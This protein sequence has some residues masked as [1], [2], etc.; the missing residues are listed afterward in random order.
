MN[1]DELIAALQTK[2]DYL[3]N[4][5]G[6]KADEIGVVVWDGDDI[7]PVTD[8]DYDKFDEDGPWVVEV[9][10]ATDP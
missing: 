10:K 7:A 1:L 2:R 3:V 6:F 8:L 5:R 9:R 4:T